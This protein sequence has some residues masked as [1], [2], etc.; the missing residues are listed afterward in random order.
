[1]IKAITNGDIWTMSGERYS[2][3]TVLIDKGKILAL[4]LST[5]I[6]IPEQAEVIDADGRL[7]TPGLIDVHT[8]LGLDEEGI[9]W[10][11]D[12]YNETSAAV[13]PH[14]R[15]LDGIN[16]FDQGFLNALQAG[17][18][19]VQVLPGSAN[20]IGGLTCCL[21]LKPTGLIDEMVIRQPAGLKIA[22]G[23]NPKKFHGKKG[24]APQTRMGIAALI[25]EQ[26]VAALNYREKKKR[27]ELE[28]NLQLEAMLLA[29]DR[30]I[31]VRAHVHRADDIVTAIRL[32]K[33][34]NLDLT[35]EHTT[36]GHK[37]AAYLADAGVRVAV[38][39]TLSSKSKVEL[40]DKDWRTYTVLAEHQIP[41]SIT[42][43]H[44]VVPI[45]HLVTTASLAVQAG[46]PEELAWQALTIQAARHLGLEE[47]VGSLEV[48]KDA[49]LVIWSC[50]PLDSY[51]RI[52]LT[53]V[54]GEI[55]Y[56]KREE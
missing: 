19:T 7:V 35:L 27:D 4:G 26:F 17:I 13:T 41:F 46:L 36:E 50:N 48:G 56:R 44:P 9:G 22:F 23:E 43:D 33:E 31:P 14:I 11:G 49:D 45:E 42:T 20:V 18:T 47:R 5:Q 55:V 34:F 53:M 21:K 32:A 6:R 38:G 30:K 52:V 40:R 8:H 25:R 12:D 54:E 51:A 24:N 37:I 10:E 39:P 16:P 3:G 28:R 15:A 2:P 1:M 29:L